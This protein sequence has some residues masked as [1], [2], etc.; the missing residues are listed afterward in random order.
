MIGYFA[1]FILE[2]VKILKFQ[3]GKFLA[4][5]SVTLF[6]IF[7]LFLVQNLVYTSDLTGP[8]ADLLV[9][10]EQTFGKD[11]LV[12]VDKVPPP[13][14]MFYLDGPYREAEY[15][16]IERTINTR[17]P[18]EQIIYITKISRHEKILGYEPKALLIK[19]LDDFALGT[20]GP[21]SKK[22][23]SLENSNLQ[24]TAPKN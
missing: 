2:R 22:V 19:R 16:E 10:K 15:S 24:N 11:T 21:D 18:D 4:L 14:V 13:V 7:Y 20:I 9:L 6:A 5:Y 1:D 3:P 8:M 23:S 17:L 12:Y